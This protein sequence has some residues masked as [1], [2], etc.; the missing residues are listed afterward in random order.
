MVLFFG[1]GG[2]HI[3]E[4]DAWNMVKGLEEEKDYPREKKSER[5]D[6]PTVKIHNIIDNRIVHTKRGE[7]DPSNPKIQDVFALKPDNA[8]LK[9]FFYTLITYITYKVH[10]HIEDGNNERNTMNKVDTE[11]LFDDFETNCNWYYDFE[12]RFPNAS[13]KMWY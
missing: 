3:G 6:V 4:F 10:A 9:A 2:D 12:K 7:N 5:T 1:N 11:R 13:Y 8:Q